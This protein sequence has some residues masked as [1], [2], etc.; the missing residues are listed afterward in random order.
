MRIVRG[1]KAP[2]IAIDVVADPTVP[3]DTMILKPATVNERHG[4]FQDLRFKKLHS[5]KVRT[6]VAVI[7]KTDGWLTVDELTI[8]ARDLEY[9][10]VLRDVRFDVGD[11]FQQGTE[12]MLRRML[13]GDNEPYTR[14]TYVISREVS[15][16]SAG[17]LTLTLHL[18]DLR[19]DG[20]FDDP[21][22]YKF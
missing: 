13:A 19:V 12:V 11:I 2:R 15:Y 8:D 5:S 1:K 22:K 6:H 16:T 17:R 7:D 18:R 10:V 4:K 3:K 9:R 14:K 20:L 21:Y